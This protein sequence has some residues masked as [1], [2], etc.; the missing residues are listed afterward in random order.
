M[1]DVGSSD[2]VDK[3]RVSRDRRAQNQ[4]AVPAVRQ[5][6]VNTAELSAAHIFEWKEA[7]LSVGTSL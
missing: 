2:D 4:P 3:W 7:H 1:K 6:C 5:N